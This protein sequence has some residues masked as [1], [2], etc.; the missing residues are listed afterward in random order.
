MAKQL[1]SLEQHQESATIK[2]VEYQQKLSHRYNH[3]IKSRE[4]SAGDSAL[5]K[6]VG[7]AWD[8]NAGKLVPNWEGPYRVT[9]ITG[10]RA[11][12]LED[13]GERSLPRPW[14]VQNLRRFYH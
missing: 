12:Y 6:V 14:N 5:R 7:N 13:M 9:A 1:D 10:A 4:F 2:L 11:Y 8:T 3:D